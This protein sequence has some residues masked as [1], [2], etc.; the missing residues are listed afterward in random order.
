MTSI[1]YLTHFRLISTQS[2]IPTEFP[3]ANGDSS[4]SPYPSHTHTH[5]NPHENPHTH[6]SPARK[7][8]QKS[9][10]RL[11]PGMTSKTDGLHSLVAGTS[12]PVSTKYAQES[13]T[14]LGIPEPL[15][16]IWGRAPSFFLFRPIPYPID[17]LTSLR[18]F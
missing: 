11:Y 2:K 5:G 18:I 12:Q 16:K 10:T 3:Q 9:G 17:A 14:K 15:D 13:V 6:G 1:A 7:I 4:Q 8:S